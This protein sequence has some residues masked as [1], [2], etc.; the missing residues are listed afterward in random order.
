MSDHNTVLCVRECPI[1]GTAQVVTGAMDGTEVITLD[2]GEVFRRLYP[3]QC[4]SRI[5]IVRFGLSAEMA[6]I[7]FNNLGEAIRRISSDDDSGDR[8]NDDEGCDF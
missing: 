2:F 8:H 1:V 6:L 5:P 4:A 7:F 3:N